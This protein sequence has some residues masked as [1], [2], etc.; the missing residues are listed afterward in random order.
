MQAFNFNTQP[1]VIGMP[2]DVIEGSSKSSFDIAGKAMRQLDDAIENRAF[3]KSIGNAQG[4][5]DLTGL[6]PTTKE[7]QAMMANKMGV[8]NA[9]ETQELARDTFDLSGDTLAETIRHNK[10]TELASL[11]GAGRYDPSSWKEY[12]LA[13]D[14]KGDSVGYKN[15]LNKRYSQGVPIKDEFGNIVGYKNVGKQIFNIGGTNTSGQAG[16]F[17]SLDSS[18]PSQLTNESQVPSIKKETRKIFSKAKVSPVDIQ[19]YDTIPQ[20]NKLF[21]SFSK[22]IPEKDTDSDYFGRADALT[23]DVAGWFGVNTEQSSKIQEVSSL[24][25]KLLGMLGKE[26]MKGV[27]SDQDLKI[28]NQNIPSPYD[29]ENQAF[30]KWKVVTDLWK[31]RVENFNSRM[32]MSGAKL[33]GEE[34]DFNKQ[35]ELPE[36][37]VTNADGSITFPDGSVYRP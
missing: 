8:F 10:A 20:V 23:G 36:G 9:L 37:S 31:N 6:N 1:Q 3:E 7:Q 5:K 29:S 30:E 2:K 27:L 13:T 16:G 26:E 15:Y 19:T 22:I 28:I 17:T 32:E 4:L 35:D 25:S 18:T 11:T 21:D 34:K 33:R 24:G 14:G 12:M